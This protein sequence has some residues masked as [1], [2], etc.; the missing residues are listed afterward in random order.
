LVQANSAFAKQDFNT[1]EASIRKLLSVSPSSQEAHVLLGRTLL[2]ANKLDEAEKEFNAALKDPLPSASTLGWSNA[3]L[4]DIALRRGQAAEAVRRYNFAAGAD[5][6]YGSTLA[7]RQG[8]IKAEAA[9]NT[10]I[11]PD[12]AVQ[13]FVGQLDAAI[14]SGHK[15]DLESLI[16][17]GD[18]TTFVKGI[19]GS[20]PEAWQ[21]RVLRTEQV[22]ANR[23]LADVSINARQLGRDVAGPAVLVL[24]RLGN[25]WKLSSIEYFEVR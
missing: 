15:N 16:V 25:G 24:S 23:M 19:V 12:A 9:A 17:P 22:D 7:A 21:T 11:A 4:G 2:G 3:G 20:Q 14:K 8:R 1:A 18:L 13:S 6:E 5:A 10:V